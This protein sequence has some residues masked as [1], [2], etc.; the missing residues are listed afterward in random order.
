MRAGNAAAAINAYTRALELAGCPTKGSQ[1]AGA[2]FCQ[3]QA[4]VNIKHFAAC[5]TTACLHLERICL[6]TAMLQLHATHPLE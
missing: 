6:H 2:L 3:L 4:S 5:D 1:A